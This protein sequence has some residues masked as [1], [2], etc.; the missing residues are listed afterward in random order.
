MV[1]LSA[2]DSQ[3]LSKALSK[4]VER[5]V[6]WNEYKKKVRIKIQQRGIGVFPKLLT[7]FFFM[8]YLS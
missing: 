6:C 4:G 1:T 8:I 3:N 7:V 5:S 2:R